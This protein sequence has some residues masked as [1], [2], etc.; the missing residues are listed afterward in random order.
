MDEEQP[1]PTVPPGLL[2]ELKRRFPDSCPQLEDS[3]RLIWF[4]VGQRSVVNFLQTMFERQNENI[5][6][7]E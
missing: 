2:E 1:F 7:K 6:T 4:H 5:L 3:D